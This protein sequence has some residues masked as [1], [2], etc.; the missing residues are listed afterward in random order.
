MRF[1]FASA[2]RFLLL[3]LWGLIL[4]PR[5]NNKSPLW[6]CGPWWTLPLTIPWSFLLSCSW[7]QSMLILVR[8]MICFL[9]SSN[10]L[11]PFI[12]KD[13]TMSGT[14]ENVILST[15][16]VF[17]TSNEF[18]PFCMISI[19]WISNRFVTTCYAVFLKIVFKHMYIYKTNGSLDQI[20][21]SYQLP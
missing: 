14:N 7:Y 18:R 10:W 3:E 19:V 4:T 1:L 8:Q 11:Y 15:Y 21:F 2:Q 20:S 12:L 17:C 9:G 13:G 6:S 16:T 5:F